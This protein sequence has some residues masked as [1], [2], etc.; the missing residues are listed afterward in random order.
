MSHWDVFISHASEDKEEVAKPLADELEIR[1]LRV[2]YDDFS[3][4]VGDSLRRSIDHGLANSRFG[5]V[6]LSPHF[7]RKRWTQLEL[8]G[9][10]ARET[11]SQ[12]LVLPVWHDI[13]I[14]EIRRVSPILAGRVGVNTSL[15]IE[16]VAG[17]LIRAMIAPTLTRELLPTDPKDECALQ[18]VD[19][20]VDE[21]SCFYVMSVEGSVTNIV[22]SEN[23]HPF[24]PSHTK[25]VFPVLDV[26]LR[27][28]SSDPSF[29]YRLGVEI[30]ETSEME[31]DREYQY[32][33]GPV[34]V[35]AKYDILLDPES[36]TKDCVHNVSLGIQPK[37]VERFQIQFASTR[38]AIYR[39]RFVL[40]F[41]VGGILKSGIFVVKIPGGY[42]FPEKVIGPTVDDKISALTDPSDKFGRIVAARALAK[43]GTVRASP[44]LVRALGD[45]DSSVRSAAAGALSS[46][47][48][49][50]A[51]EPL[52]SVLRSDSHNGAKA[53]AA[54]ALGFQGSNE[55]VPDLIAALETGDENLQGS[56][57]SALGELQ[58]NR[59]AKALALVARKSPS[60]IVQWRA[61]EALGKL[62][63]EVA[64]Q[65][66]LAL[67]SKDSPSQAV[68]S[69]LRGQKDRRSEP[70]FLD[71]IK[72]SDQWMRREAAEA[73][74]DLRTE[75]ARAA[76]R[77][78]VHRDHEAGVRSAAAFSLA[79]LG[80][81]K[82]FLSSI[83]SSSLADKHLLEKYANTAG[84]ES[85]PL[86][87]KIIESSVNIEAKVVAGIALARFGERRGL[88][89]LEE[90][91]KPT[92][93]GV[94]AAETLGKMA[95]QSGIDF[96]KI[97]L[98]DTSDKAL[99][100]SASCALA[101]L[102]DSSG[103]S[104]LI[105]ALP[106]MASWSGQP[107]DRSRHA[108]LFLGLNTNIT[109]IAEALRELGDWEALPRLHEAW[110]A[111]QQRTESSVW[112]SMYNDPLVGIERTVEHL[113][114]LFQQY[115]AG[116]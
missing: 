45:P 102:G 35:S 39:L 88:L 63:C 76:L 56:A 37:G 47:G 38:S 59:S 60:S 65:C 55:S 13:D 62:S 81:P 92:D 58:D 5:I 8:D 84:L 26:K 115:S 82:Y 67:A 69:A 50:E 3:L 95:V 78:L 17:S 42:M 83:E 105:N 6:V 44:F 7:F 68:V 32:P 41:D 23:F 43:V 75:G 94:K 85:I 53:E 29:I 34:V 46:C 36:S 1:G 49:E 112:G 57:C 20:S 24:S 109:E 64:I 87:V 74:G 101:R 9:L 25:N 96:L 27:N 100:V 14:G 91:L 31:W 90:V 33:C 72:H 4:T 97:C 108:Y 22:P 51:I 103:F 48:D 10:F 18:V 80:E 52:L 40:Y 16:K 71:W 21:E 110:H 73:L 12:K 11:T 77:I 15:G 28:L 99:S 116:K 89:F 104:I 107:R 111:I 61:I 2:W 30:L 19:I 93:L 114:Q 86:L 106:E 70:L 54:F 79:V 113:D 98:Q 66:L